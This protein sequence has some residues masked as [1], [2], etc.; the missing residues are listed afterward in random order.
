MGE[1]VKVCVPRMIFLG[2]AAGACAR[3]EPERVVSGL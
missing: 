2:H 3:R 1:G